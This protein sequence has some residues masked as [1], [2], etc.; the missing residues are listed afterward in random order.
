MANA[1][2]F[3]FV[4]VEQ[5][6]GNSSL[7]PLLPLTLSIGP[8]SLEVSALLDTGSS[9]NV[10]PYQAGISLGAKWEKQDVEIQLTGNLACIEARALLLEATVSDIPPVRM[11]FAWTKT[12]EVPVLLGQVNFFLEFEVCFF[13]SQRFFEVRRNT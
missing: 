10:L 6:L 3:P 4:A 5:S 8:N 13:R 11:A 7:Q 2:R 1:L 12:D 9:V